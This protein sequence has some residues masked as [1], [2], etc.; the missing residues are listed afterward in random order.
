MSDVAALDARVTR[1]EA[2][3][4]AGFERLERLLRTEISD[5]KTEQITDLREANKRLADDQRRL[6]EALRDLERRESQ[7]VGGRRV[8]SS[9]GHF[10]SAGVGALLTWIATWL[11]SGR[12]PS[13]P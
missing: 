3:I 4:T 10:L 7:R 5:L 9:I 1:L 8:L 13:H 6:W 11:S 12:P 2:A